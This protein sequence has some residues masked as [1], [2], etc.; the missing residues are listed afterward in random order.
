MKNGQL[1]GLMQ[2]INSCGNLSGFKFA[3]TM[4]K[5]KK[6]IETEIQAFNELLKADNKFLEYENKRIDLCNKHAKKDEDGKAIMIKEGNSERFDIENE[7]KFNKDFSKL[8][9]E[10]K[11]AIEARDE[12]I[13]K[14]NEFM[15]EDSTVELR[16]VD[17]DDVPEEITS[18]QLNSIIDLIDE[19]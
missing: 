1:T 8:K 10:F 6:A 19:S 5:N 15:L 9:V 17:E 11:S 7:D 12:Q 14:F 4:A 16:K 3:Y 18:A 2:G 13:K